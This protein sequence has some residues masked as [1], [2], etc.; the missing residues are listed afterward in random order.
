MSIH[1]AA[2]TGFAKGAVTYVK[3]RPDYPPEVEDWLR[4]DLALRKGKTV[5]DLG[6]G[7]GKFIPSLRTT[8]AASGNPERSMAHSG[9][10]YRPVVPTR[11]RR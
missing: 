3:G 7:T 4:G 11:H 8:D 9:S 2:A 5:L 1:R 10:S 6:A